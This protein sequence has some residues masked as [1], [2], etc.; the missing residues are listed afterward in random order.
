MLSTKPKFSSFYLD[1]S[2]ED[3]YIALER[4]GKR[5]EE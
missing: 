1:L 4:N 2:V 5:N 3:I